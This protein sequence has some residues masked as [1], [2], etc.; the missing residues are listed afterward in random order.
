MW[1]RERHV[2]SG[3]LLH[4]DIASVLKQLEPPLSDRVVIR[5]YEGFARSD[6]AERASCERMVQ[7]ASKERP[8]VGS[9]ACTNG[10]AFLAQTVE[11]FLVAE[12]LAARMAELAPERVIVWMGLPLRNDEL[13]GEEGSY[14]D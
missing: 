5:A 1:L 12:R 7:V 9:V 2:L 3:C 13:E 8:R 6:I 10:T 11:D 14:P 4:R